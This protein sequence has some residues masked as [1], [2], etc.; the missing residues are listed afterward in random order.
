[1]L[2]INIEENLFVCPFML[3]ASHMERPF[4]VCRQQGEICAATFPCA[5]PARIEV[6]HL[7]LSYEI[8]Q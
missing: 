3:L 4:G 7:S 5:S 1:M 6:D 2:V 8:K